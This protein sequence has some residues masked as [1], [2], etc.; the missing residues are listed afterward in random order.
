MEKDNEKIPRF[1][2]ES[3]ISHSDR[4]NKR[5]FILCIILIIALLATNV[6]WVIY[7]SQFEDYVVTQEND[8]GY[9]NFIGNDGD[10]YNG[11]TNDKIPAP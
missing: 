1:A 11:E 7:E 6:G 4:V 9:N 8:D 2:Y 5:L 10:I 3:A